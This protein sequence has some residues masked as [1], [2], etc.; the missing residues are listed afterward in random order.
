MSLPRALIMSIRTHQL[1][2]SRLW[3]RWL[4]TIR[5]DGDACADALQRDLLTHHELRSQAAGEPRPSGGQRQGRA[6]QRQGAAPA[7]R[8]RGDVAA[9]AEALLPGPSAACRRQRCGDDDPDLPFTAC[10][11]A[12]DRQIECGI[13]S[14]GWMTAALS[15]SSPAGAGVCSTATCLAL[16][17][18][19]GL[20][21]SD[22]GRDVYACDVAGT[23][24][25]TGSTHDL[26]ASG[27]RLFGLAVGPAKLQVKIYEF[28][29]YLDAKQVWNACMVLS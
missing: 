21:V 4:T 25:F 11:S 5:G 6:G 29:L 2:V 18:W 3:P 20:N 7:A 9:A 28:A 12:F 23:A 8:W 1:F 14:Q 13:L 19:Q 26:A 27:T 16:R 24:A 15:S 10:K 22:A 17:E